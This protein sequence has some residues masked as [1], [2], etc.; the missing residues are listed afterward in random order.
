MLPVSVSVSPLAHSKTLSPSCQGAMLSCRTRVY[1]RMLEDKSTLKQIVKKYKGDDNSSVSK[2]LTPSALKAILKKHPASYDAETHK[3]HLTAIRNALNKSGT[4]Y[5]LADFSYAGTPSGCSHMRPDCVVT[6]GLVS[7]A[8]LLIG[9]DQPQ[10]D[11]SDR[12]TAVSS[13]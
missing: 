13:V 3:K 5:I 12:A 9:L 11:E 10:R 2:S 7:I 8:A 1:S 6:Q 4:G